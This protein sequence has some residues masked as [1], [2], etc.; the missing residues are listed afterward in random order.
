MNTLIDLSLTTIFALPGSILLRSCLTRLD[1]GTAR[2][3]VILWLA[4][5]FGGVASL[6]LLHV[7]LIQGLGLTNFDPGA[8]AIR[9]GL[10]CGTAAATIDLLVLVRKHVHLVERQLGRRSQM[11]FDYYLMMVFT[12]LLII[13]NARYDGR[14]DRSREFDP[15]R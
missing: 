6:C 7:T 11:L 15:D 13:F 1:G 10:C 4:G 8:T 3:R 5:Y 9:W 14:W 2:Q 12:A